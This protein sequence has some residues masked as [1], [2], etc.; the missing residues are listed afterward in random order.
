MATVGIVVLVVGLGFIIVLCICG[1]TGVCFK[2]RCYCC[3]NKGADVKEPSIKTISDGKK[4]PWKLIHK[5]ENM[6][7]LFQG[8]PYK[9]VY[10]DAN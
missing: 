2:N 10:D 9:H 5:T 7:S 4:I 1:L 6:Y 8:I 3:A